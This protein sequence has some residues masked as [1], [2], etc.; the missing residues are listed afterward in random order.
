MGRWSNLPANGARKKT[1]LLMLSSHF[2]LTL[3]IKK[4][5]A[6][7]LDPARPPTGRDYDADSAW[8]ELRPPRDS[9]ATYK[10]RCLASLRYTHNLIRSR[11]SQSDPRL[12]LLPP[13]EDI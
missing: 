3:E 10:P 6:T 13:K 12:T 11:A 8:I 5:S 9:A 7:R 2:T 4:P 1:R